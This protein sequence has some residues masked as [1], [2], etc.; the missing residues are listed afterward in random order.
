MAPAPVWE[1]VGGGD[2][3]GILVRQGSEL[4]SQ[5]CSERLSTGAVVEE[6]ERLGE[7]LRYRRLQGLGPESGWVTV[8][9][10]LKELLRKT[11]DTSRNG[12]EDDA[13]GE[14]TSKAASPG[15]FQQK[16]ATGKKVRIISLKREDYQK[17]NGKNGAIMGFDP[18]T[19][20]Y[21]V[22]VVI[23]SDKSVGLQA[24]GATLL[25][26]KEDNIELHPDQIERDQVGNGDEIVLLGA[27]EA[28]RK[29]YEVRLDPQ[30]WYDK[31]IERVLE[32]RNDFEVLDL[33]PQ[34]I[35]DLS[36]LKKAYRKISLSV[37]P[38][39]NKH[40]Q[41]ADAFRKV[42]GA[43]ETL[44]DTRQ[45]RRLLWILGK[46]TPDMEEKVLFDEEEEDELFQW[47]WEATV[48]EIEKQ[49]AEFEG[50]QFDDYGAMWISDG[51]GG[52]VEEVKWIGL[53]T[54]KRLHKDEEGVIFIDVRDRRDFAA[55][56]IADA[57]CTPLPEIIDYG[58]VNVFMAADDQLIHKL[59]KHRTK[60]IIVYSE[61]A[62][63]F[64]R[65]RAFCRW[66]L[67]AGH[68]T[69]KVERVRR[70]RGG[71]F[72]W[73]HKNGPV[74]RPLQDSSYELTDSAEKDVSRLSAGR[75]EDMDSLD[76]S[77]HGWARVRTWTRSVRRR[78]PA[79]IF[80]C[81]YLFLPLHHEAERHWSLAV[82]CRPWA[83]VNIGQDVHT[84]T[85]VAFLDSLRS[86]SSE[87]HEAVVLHKLKS[88]LRSEWQD[89]TPL[90]TS[91]DEGRIQAVAIDVP[92]QQNSSDCGIYVL[93]FMLQLLCHPGKL[94]SLGRDPLAVELQVGKAPR[95]R[96][97][98]AGASYRSLKQAAAGG[99]A[100]FDEESWMEMLLVR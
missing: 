1:V 71:I 77:E 40:P 13:P 60:P 6:L 53:E 27:G 65:C 83:A 11:A 22:K 33:P 41:S 16:I 26:L 14:R 81:D 63:P 97:R 74:A 28:K 96:W 90:S 4:S 100:S 89:C 17:Y 67:R 2:F 46:L 8:R 5:P 57:F 24:E 45:Q 56:H 72:G 18:A 52:D 36:I 9:L 19:G 98:Q 32:S 80:A 92:Q 87:K 39:K 86:P 37:H 48:P 85:T 58:L 84:T 68:Q 15:G 91:F 34:L 95:Q 94:A 25:L 69:I 29:L 55:G 82:V 23:L 31:A 20:R 3:G 42:Y 47:W 7:R 10:G 78:H 88:Y 99:S 93:E 50:Q 54:A 51:L 49:V 64:S 79:G 75:Q 35:T 62:T 12:A 59:L 21:S 76:A 38:D 30:Y 43:F 61:V 66:L 70:L 44:M 73:K